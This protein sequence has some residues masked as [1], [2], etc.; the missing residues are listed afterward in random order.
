[1][2]QT[3]I[4]IRLMYVCLYVHLHR[5]VVICTFLVVYRPKFPYTFGMLPG[6]AFTRHPG[7]NGSLQLYYNNSGICGCLDLPL[8]AAI[9]MQVTN[10]LSR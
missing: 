2:H 10:T 1:M 4:N 7:G 5:T 9:L 8:Q 3:S 6:H